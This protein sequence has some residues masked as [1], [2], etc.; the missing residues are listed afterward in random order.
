MKVPK[1]FLYLPLIALLIFA[2]SVLAVHYRNLFQA[3]SRA[4]NDVVLP[5]SSMDRA[6]AYVEPEGE[7]AG[8]K[9]EDKIIA[10][11]GKTIDD[12]AAYIKEITKPRH[13]TA[14]PR[15]STLSMIRKR[16]I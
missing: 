9:R 8:F 5:F 13:P 14:T 1:K 12:N 10:I 11:N 15:F 7:A 4:S 16:G 3:L 2:L 6:I